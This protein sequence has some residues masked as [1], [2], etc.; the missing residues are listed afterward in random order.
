[1][2][3]FQKEALNANK[4]MA[5]ASFFFLFLAIFITQNPLSAVY[6][7]NVPDESKFHVKF[8]VQ[9]GSAEKG[10]FI[11]EVNPAWA[12]LGVK[13]FKELI[14]INFFKVGKKSFSDSVDTPVTPEI[15]GCQIFPRDQ[16]FHG[17]VWNS[18]RS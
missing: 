12:P 17:T 4:V 18:W 9:L 15:E 11:M 3:I 16:G 13:R 10:E 2:K 6:A 14:D 7:E 5:I 1:M 8:E